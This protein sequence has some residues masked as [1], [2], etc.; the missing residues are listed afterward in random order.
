MLCARSSPRNK[1]GRRWS[2]CTVRLRER[3]VLVITAYLFAGLLLDSPENTQVL[4]ELAALIAF[5]GLPTV[6]CADW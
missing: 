4:K 2:A 3:T 1:V 5:H 6:A